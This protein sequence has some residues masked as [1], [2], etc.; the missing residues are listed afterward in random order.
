MKLKWTLLIVI[1]IF[2]VLGGIGLILQIY[3]TLP[4]E[5]K[6]IEIMK[7]AFLVLGGLGVVLP[8]YLNI[9]Q[10]LESS[11]VLEEK[12][13]FDRM[14]NSFRILENWD[15]PSLLEARRFTRRI[16]DTRTSLS[17]NQLIEEIDKNETLKES[18]IMVFNYWEGV[19]IS[20]W[21]NRVNEPILFD[22]IGEIYLDMFERF[23]PWIRQDEL[24]LR[25]FSELYK[26]W[27]KFENR[28]QL[29][30]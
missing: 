28:H 10:S 24:R 27:N 1:T 11:Q 22:S 29:G 8:T 12:I 16:K 17:D 30:N 23:K 7:S 2:W 4:E 18:V 20:I 3:P 25:H 19:R 6:V 26:R 9:W 21:G 5:T 14:E 13:Q 15:D